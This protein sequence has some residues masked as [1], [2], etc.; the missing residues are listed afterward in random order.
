MFNRSFSSTN[1]LNAAISDATAQFNNMANFQ[2][3]YFDV[4]EQNTLQPSRDTSKRL[5]ALGAILG[6]QVRLIDNQE[7]Q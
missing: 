4:A 2:L 5:V 3:D 7:L 6:S 1:S